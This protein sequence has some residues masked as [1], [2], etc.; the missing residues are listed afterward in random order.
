M[1]KQKKT[2]FFKRILIDLFIIGAS[3]GGIA[4]FTNRY[5]KVTNADR[6]L[7]GEFIDDFNTTPKGKP[8]RLPLQKNPIPVV[9]EELDDK[10]KNNIIEG[11]NALDNISEKINYDIYSEN[12]FNRNKN[13]LHIYIEV[14]DKFEEDDK[15][16][17]TAGVAMIK[18]SALTAKIQY[19]I[20]IQ[21][22]DRVVSQPYGEEEKKALLTSIVKHELMHTLGFR[23]LY[24]EEDKHRSIMYYLKDYDTVLD[25]T[26]EDIKKIQ[27]VYDRKF[28]VSV[29][30]P[31]T[32]L[33]YKAEHEKAKEEELTM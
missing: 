29:E 8:L 13:N 12:E 6:E 5:S 27:Y 26:K 16:C 20:V 31:D 33:C 11:V 32:I 1:K 3:V 24:K 4:E 14:I 10:T 19:P 17:V 7:F 30:R 25:Y 28:D 22:S 15:D 2:N 23:D 9:I 21:I 18:A